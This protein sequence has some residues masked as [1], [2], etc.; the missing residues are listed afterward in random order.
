MNRVIIPKSP[1]LLCAEGL[2]VADIRS[3]FSKTHIIG[4]T[5]DTAPLIHDTL[6]ELTALAIS[7][8]EKERIAEERRSIAYIVD[9]RY[10]G[11]SHE[12]RVPLDSI[13]ESGAA[14]S[15]LLAEFKRAHQR[16]YGFAPDDEVELVTFRVVATAS[17]YSYPREIPQPDRDQTGV[18]LAKRDVY[19]EELGGYVSC[20]VYDRMRLRVGT[21]ITGPVILEQMDTTTVVRPFQW[22]CVQPFG[23][24]ILHIAKS[25]GPQ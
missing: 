22:V 5:S 8:F 20:D 3:D 6:Q 2:L 10:K 13:D 7:W 14:L 23:E 19:F 12:L 25:Q 11:Q 21:E 24:I 17:T 16:L 9:M 15:K 4:L 18:R 1:G